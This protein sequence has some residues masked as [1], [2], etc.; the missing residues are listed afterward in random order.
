LPPS[1]RPLARPGV[2]VRIR[3]SICVSTLRSFG[4]FGL[5]NVTASP[6]KTTRLTQS[7]E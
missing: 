4:V 2:I 5:L 6:L 3:L 7:S 1:S